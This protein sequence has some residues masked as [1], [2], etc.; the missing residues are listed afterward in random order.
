MV[1][2]CNNRPAALQILRGLEWK[3]DPVLHARLVRL[4]GQHPLDWETL[5]ADAEFRR[6]VQALEQL[7]AGHTLDLELEP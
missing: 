7:A 2:I 1:L 6:Q 4:H 3:P 5:H